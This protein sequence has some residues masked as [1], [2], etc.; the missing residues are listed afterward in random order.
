MKGCILALYHM[1]HGGQV[2]NN[3]GHMLWLHWHRREKSEQHTVARVADTG[4]TG[5]QVPT[6]PRPG[7]SSAS[8]NTQKNCVML[9]LPTF[10]MPYLR[11]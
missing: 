4:H 2:C 5:D 9:L 6:G 8:S 11:N 1:W 10:H 3:N 7:L